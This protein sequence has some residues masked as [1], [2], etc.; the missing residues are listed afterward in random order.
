[1]A[2]GQG[3]AR[4]PRP[5]GE[6][7]RLVLILVSAL[8]LFESPTSGADDWITGTGGRPDRSGLST[9]HGPTAAAVLWD[10]CLDISF[11]GIQAVIGGDVVVSSRV[12]GDAWID[13]Q[14]LHTGESLW[15]VALPVNF[16]DSWWSHA[17]AIRDGQVY[18]SRAGNTNSEY[19]YALSV[20][21]GSI[22]WKSEA[23]IDSSVVETP[24]FTEEGDLIVGNLGSILR[25]DHTNGH[26]M[27]Q[28]PRVCQN[29]G[30]CEAAVSG[31][32]V[33]GW[34]FVG[35]GSLHYHVTAYDVATGGWLYTSPT[36][37]ASGFGIQQIGLLAGPFGAVYAPMAYN[38]PDDAFIAL[39]DSGSALTE[40]W[41]VPIGY[42]PFASFGIGPD[43]T[44]YMYSQ[45]RE[46]LR[47]DPADGNVLNTS[48]SLMPVLPDGG[49]FTPKMAIDARG[50]VFVTNTYDTLFAFDPDLRL[51]WASPVPDVSYGGPAIAADGTLVV[52]G[53]G[54]TVRAF[55]T[56]FSGDSPLRADAHTNGSTSSNGN[57]VLEPGETVLVEPSWE[58]GSAADVPALDS[59][60][61]NFTGPGGGEYSI[62]EP[63]G[64]YGAVAA[65][66][67]ANCFDTTGNCPRMRVGNPGTRPA[68]HWDATFQE[69]LNTSSGRTWMLHVGGSF[70][71]V[72]G[73]YL[74]YSFVETV[75]HNGVTAGCG[76]GTT[77]CPNASVTR[78]QMAVFLLRSRHGSSFVPPPATGTIFEDVPADSFA[79]DW[80]EELANEG[81]T[82][83][84]SQT[85]SLYCPTAPV[86]RAQMA[87]FL[88]KM[89][90]GKRFLPAPC[91]GLFA[92]VVCPD[93]FA[94]D[95]IETLAAEDVTAGCGGNDYCPTAPNT[96]GQMAAFLVK[97]FGLRLYGP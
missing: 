42:V 63:G 44:V 34:E 2:V 33:Y 88:L 60:S 47:L 92:D 17:M 21:D 84:C 87:V 4:R 43:G 13:A 59:M 18:A 28:T 64:Q 76:G 52:T 97:T 82:G 15:S 36:L 11:G 8:L 35:S 41:R 25:I 9:G 65:G 79:A 5:G 55:A 26:T 24:S 22:V 48:P 32:R 23:L 30:G 68:T 96:R 6:L 29:T 58:N 31:S 7:S 85:P 54:T 45:D 40:I 49:A 89:E 71:D 69:T 75:L 62:D 10:T 51:R 27:W 46:V 73:S 95:W 94:A 37:R 90:H 86:T 1:M 3:L 39:S 19:L 93:G 57:G 77:Y 38:A 74:F 70:D 56:P 78:A 66:A 50:R 16:P 81:I 12:L 61:T 53:S 83:G 20:S 72:P 14:N 80:I 67:S 91:A